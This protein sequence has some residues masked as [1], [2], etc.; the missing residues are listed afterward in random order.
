MKAVFLDRDGV[1]CRNR[2]DYVKNWDEFQF[3]PHS[4]EAIARLT[5]AGLPVIVIS[6]QSAINR[7]LTSAD[8][9][10]NIH[11]HMI[12]E[13]KAWG[14]SIARVY[15]CPHKPDEHCICRKPQPGML[16]QAALELGVNL[17]ESFLI[18]DAVTDIQAAQAVGVKAYLVMTGRGKRQ[19]L[20]AFT[21]EMDCFNV[22]S[23]L[24]QAVDNILK[25]ESLATQHHKWAMVQREMARS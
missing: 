8:E 20:G 25:L 13:V 2:N 24:W 15:Y 3:L 4:R 18:G 12:S 7:G 11:R 17:D 1:I 5:K 9:V 19:D 22:A 10:E 14:G 6:N 23:N 16:L 21:P